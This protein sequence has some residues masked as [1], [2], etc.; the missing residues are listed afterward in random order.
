MRDAFGGRRRAVDCSSDRLSRG[1]CRQGKSGDQKRREKG[2]THLGFLRVHKKTLLRREN[3]E[4][5]EKFL[6]ALAGS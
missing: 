2:E 4:G 5:G 6:D 1:L 3:G